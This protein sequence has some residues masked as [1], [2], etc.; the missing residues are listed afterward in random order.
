M[1]AGP[2]RK[3]ASCEAGDDRGREESPDIVLRHVDRSAFT[4]MGAGPR[5][6][7]LPGIM[8][9]ALKEGTMYRAPTKIARNKKDAEVNGERSTELLTGQRAW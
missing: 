4:L 5:R 8:R 1:I 3:P 6:A 2:G 9:I 7:R